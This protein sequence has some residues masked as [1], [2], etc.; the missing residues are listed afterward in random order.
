[1][2][3]EAVCDLAVIV[4][5]ARAACLC[6][7]LPLRPSLSITDSLTGYFVLFSLFLCLELKFK[8]EEEKYICDTRVLAVDPVRKTEGTK[9][10]ALGGRRMEIG[11]SSR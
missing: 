10:Q 8:S 1:M 4:N 6:V 3:V 5:S 9:S 2:K 11:D 7:S